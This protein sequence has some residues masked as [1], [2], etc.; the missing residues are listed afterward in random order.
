LSYSIHCPL[1]VGG[2]L[3]NSSRLKLLFY[4]IPTC[5][6]GFQVAALLHDLGHP[7]FSHVIEFTLE[8]AHD[9]VRRSSIKQYIQ[10]DDAWLLPM[11]YQTAKGGDYRAERASVTN[12][13]QASYG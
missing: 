4:N 8:Q 6:L 9:E 13:N 5:G 3:T 2:L 10:W 1:S 7:P 11:T 12:C